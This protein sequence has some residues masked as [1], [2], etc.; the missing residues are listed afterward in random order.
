MESFEYAQPTGLEEALTLLA[1]PGTLAQAG[2][3]DLLDRLKE[4]L[5]TPKRLV[6]LRK[7]KELSGIT[8]EAGGLRV[9]ALA[10]LD[11]LAEH[12]LMRSRARAL[13]EAALHTATPNV[14]NQATIGGNLVQRPR[15]WYFRSDD[16]H[17]RK[18]GGPVCYALEGE[19]E[20]HSI[21][22]NGV[23]AALHASTLAPALVALGATLDL[24]SKKGPRTLPVSD[25]FMPPEREVTKDTVLEPGELLR[26]ILVPLG[27]PTDRSAYQKQGQRE[28]YDWPLVDVA[29][30]L[31]LEGETVRDLRI[32]LGAV[33]PVPRRATAAETLLRGKKLT[34]AL[35]Q[36][37]GAQATQGATPLAKNRYKLP[38]LSAVVARTLL[39]AERGA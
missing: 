23:C 9:G 19:N 6:S 37:A 31:R 15:C 27:E 33:A 25:F 34:E 8:E 4:G 38:L 3:V 12:P 1:E 21:F 16:F 32:V 11:E 28:S 14:R 22:G 5:D 2:G 30:W 17:C 7:V 13:A 36:A 35:A 20:L 39:S 29:V 24:V 18:K 26:S 10:T